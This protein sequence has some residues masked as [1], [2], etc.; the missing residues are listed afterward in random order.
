MMPIIVR[1]ARRAF[2]DYDAELREELV[3]EAVANCLVAYVRLVELGK[4]DIAYP[5]VL[6]RYAVAQI[7]DGRKVGGQL[8]TNE[9]LSRYAQQRKDITVERL[10]RYDKDTGQWQEA[11]IEDRRTG[12]AETAAARMDVSEWLAQLPRRNRRIAEMLA[13]GCGTAETAKRFRLSAGRVSQLRSELRDNWRAF[14]GEDADSRV[15]Y[16]VAA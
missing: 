10:D 9:V 8:N 6:A 2:R 4:Q 12:P 14:Q 1:H 11:I 13:L 15:V 5:I 3:Q 7:N 16:E